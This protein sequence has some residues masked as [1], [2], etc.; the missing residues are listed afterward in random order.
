[1][2]LDLPVNC[3]IFSQ[4]NWVPQLREKVRTLITL[5][6][7]IPDCAHVAK[8][9]GFICFNN[10]M[11]WQWKLL[12]QKHESLYLVFAK[13]E[14]VLLLLHIL[15]CYC[16]KTL[17]EWNVN[18]HRTNFRRGILHMEK[19]GDPKIKHHRSNY[20]G[21]Y[22]WESEALWFFEVNPLQKHNIN[23]YCCAIAIC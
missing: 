6:P 13:S 1:M 21:V 4:Y 12:N 19:R 7:D 22:I 20:R 17:I 5:A 18:E 9:Q 15:K 3:N 14:L 16:N 11:T 10:F 23:F 2:S 8:M